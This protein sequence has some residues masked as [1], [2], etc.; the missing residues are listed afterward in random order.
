LAFACSICVWNSDGSSRARTCPLRT[1]ELK[2]AL[3]SMMVPDTC[4]P[5]CTVVTACNVPVAPTVS[6]MSPRV[7][8]AIVTVGSGAACRYL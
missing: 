4:V 7:T 3:S 6:T 8:A 2:S 1:S 5:T